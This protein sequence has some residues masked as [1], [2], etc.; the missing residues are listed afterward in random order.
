MLVHTKF[1]VLVGD[2]VDDL[3]LILSLVSAPD[4]RQIAK[5][6]H[7]SIPNGSSDVRPKEQL[8]QALI[9]H[10]AKQRSLLSFTRG[11][12]PASHSNAMANVIQKK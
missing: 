3:H 12:N 8:I 6:L 4:L 2:S 5:S 9:T 10:S 7:V 11:G 1:L